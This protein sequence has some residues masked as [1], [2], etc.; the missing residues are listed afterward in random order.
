MKVFGG[1]GHNSNNSYSRSPDR[2]QQERPS[3]GRRAPEPR[4]PKKRGKGVLI[5]LLVIA[6]LVLGVFVYW[7]VTTKAPEV[8]APSGDPDIENNKYNEE[9]YYTLLVVGDD[10]EGGNTDTMMVMRFDTV[11]MTA[12]VV[13][14]PRD[15]AVNSDLDNKK[16]N[17]IYHNKGGIE[18]LLD[19]VERIAGFRPNNYVMV[20]MEV[21]IDVVEALGGIEFDVPLDMDYDDWSD[22]NDDGIFEYEFH[23]HLNAG[24]QTLSGYDALGVFRF[25]QNNNG[26]G[27]PMGDIQRIEVQHNLM[28]AIAGKAMSTRNVAT[29]WN[30]ASSVLDRCETDLKAGNIQWY[31][32]KFMGMSLDNI[33]FFTAPTSS[34]MV[35][36]AAYE[37]LRIDEWITMVNEKLNPYSK[38]IR[39]EDCAILNY[40]NGNING[41]G[42]MI[43]QPMDFY[44]TNGEKVFTN[45]Y[46]K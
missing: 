46:K 14:I 41:Q 20:D 15:T 44:C 5:T 3:P 1:N 38:E 10:Q 9:R 22:H 16:I 28:M 2:G 11:E 31:I 40:S 33:S 29:L 24:Q 13:S 8:V 21:F 39:A 34:F 25:R 26:S 36:D 30:I 23:I 19:E 12:N 37:Q 18:A 45:F 43:V 27:Y 7:K 35:Y 32:E 17:A 42:F 4:K 6:A